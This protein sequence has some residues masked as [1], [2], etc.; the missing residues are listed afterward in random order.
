MRSQNVGIVGLALL[1][2]AF[3]AP[4]QASAYASYTVDVDTTTTAS[5]SGTGSISIENYYSG[6]NAGGFYSDAGGGSSVISQ[7]ANST[8]GS[9]TGSVSGEFDIMLSGVATGA[10]QARGFRRSNENRTVQNTNNAST[11]GT[12]LTVT[13]LTASTDLSLDMTLD[14]LLGTADSGGNTTWASA[15][16][17]VTYQT[18]AAGT[19]TWSNWMPNCGT[20]SY[21][22][23]ATPFDDVN[24][25][26]HQLA[27]DAGGSARTAARARMM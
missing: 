17:F 5:L 23:G 18:R 4:Q 25:G 16:W 6:V 21:F 15:Y 12:V 24:T 13:G 1:G 7:Q 14:Y 27:Y 9:G 22:C 19:T 3:V 26:D 8:S 11:L 2:V 20:T 10:S